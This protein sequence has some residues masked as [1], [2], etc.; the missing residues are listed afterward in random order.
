M[1]IKKSIPTLLLAILLSV[2]LAGCGGDSA[3]NSGPGGAAT[4]PA[5]TSSGNAT[6]SGSNGPTSSTGSASSSPAVNTGS[7]SGTIKLSVVKYV[8]IPAEEG[9]L[10]SYYLGIVRN[11]GTVPAMQLQM[12]LM[13]DSGKQTNASGTLLEF[14]NLPP[15]Q[16]IGFNLAYTGQNP[17]NHPQ[18][19]VDG[20]AVDSSIAFQFGKLTVL[21]QQRGTSSDGYPTL[22]GEVRNDGDKEIDLWEVNII[23]YDASGNIVDV[24]SAS[25]A[26]DSTF[27]A[28]TTAKFRTILSDRGAKAAR[29]DLFATGQV[30]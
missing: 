13:D 14:G 24:G 23:A 2:T 4:Q 17:I 8:L 28:H 16:S 9:G 5:S 12:H 7:A 27:P 26:G 3:S 1:K 22:E 29:Y 25:P 18:F 15:G 11:D 10:T 20:V 30:G 6:G 19:K 21:S